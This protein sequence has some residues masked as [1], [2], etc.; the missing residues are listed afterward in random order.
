[1]A[2][3][4]RASGSGTNQ[5]P[6]VCMASGQANAEAMDDCCPAQT[7]RQHKDP[8]IVC[9]GD[10]GASPAIDEGMSGTLKAAGSPPAIA[11]PHNAAGRR[12]GCL[13]G[14]LTPW[15][16]QTNRVYGEGGAAPTACARSSGSGLDRQAVCQEAEGG[17]VVRRLMPI[18]CERL[19]GFPDGWTDVEHRGKPASD[20]ARYKALG[21]SMAVPVMGWIGK[22]IEEAMS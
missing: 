11:L 7:A 4:L 21:N 6:C 1:M 14:C 8:P 9:M 16:T 18:E 15:D 20:A 17:Y 10:D 5:V 2:P 12:A 22:R 19:Q 3:T 13:S